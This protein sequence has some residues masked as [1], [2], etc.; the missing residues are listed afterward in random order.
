MALVYENFIIDDTNNFLT[1]GTAVF[2]VDPNKIAHITL[3]G[4]DGQKN[5][6]TVGTINNTVNDLTTAIIDEMINR[7]GINN[8]IL[9]SPQQFLSSQG[10]SN[11]TNDQDFL[12]NLCDSIENQNIDTHISI[13]CFAHTSLFWAFKRMNP[14][15]PDISFFESLT[16]LTNNAN[17]AFFKDPSNWTFDAPI[18]DPS[19]LTSG[20]HFKPSSTNNEVGQ[21][22]NTS[23]VLNTSN[24]PL[25]VSVEGV[26][27]FPQYKI[28]EA[29]HFLKRN[30]QTPINWS[31]THELNFE[32]YIGDL[33]IGDSVFAVS[34]T[35]F[36]T[37][38]ILKENEITL[39]PPLTTVCNNSGESFIGTA[40]FYSN[41]STNNTLWS[42]LKTLDLSA[43]NQINAQA[44]YT[45]ATDA[46]IAFE[47]LNTLDLSSVKSIDDK[48]FYNKGPKGSNAW[49]SVTELNLKDLEVMNE[50]TF[51]SSTSTG[52]NNSWQK[53]E[54]LNIPTLETVPQ[55][56]FESI[57][58]HINNSWSNLTSITLTS[59]ITI[60]E[61]AFSS[62]ST[63]DNNAFQKLA[64]L[65]VPNTD[66]I[67]TKAFSS[68]SSLAK[69]NA[70]RKITFLDLSSVST[71]DESAF[72]ALGETENNTFEA[73]VSLV[74]SIKVILSD[75]SFFTFSNTTN[76]SFKN[77][78]ALISTDNSTVNLTVATLNNAF[79]KQ[80]QSNTP[81]PKFKNNV[82]PWQVT[83]GLT[84]K[85][86][87][88]L[89][90]GANWSKVTTQRNL[91]IEFDP[92][93]VLT[94][95]T[96]QKITIKGESNLQSA[97][98]DFVLIDS[99][100]NT[101]GPFSVIASSSINTN[102][103]FS[104]TLNINET[105]QPGE[106]TLEDVTALNNVPS[107]SIT[108]TEAVTK[109]LLVRFFPFL[110]MFSHIIFIALLINIT[111][112]KAKATA[113]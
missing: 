88:L 53:V 94:I 61:E 54:T 39:L 15:S 9:I 6:I 106:Y 7:G 20:T 87:M 25:L 43:A 12:D 62:S 99:N 90:S 92:N 2:Y 71:I 89:S 69:N 68:Q 23:L 63:Q 34:N 5:N 45:E 85:D 26:M 67:K 47:N 55:K 59:A 109:P 80:D 102:N 8:M 32:N 4:T 11:L 16:N 30:A 86:E 83:P 77:L 18:L 14:V 60:D 24:Q 110:V 33:L 21:Y 22:I 37:V 112:R 107:L 104:F 56:S 82:I 81:N 105:L 100:Q 49:S 70:F 108:I 31:N 65:D 40:A 50:E 93:N 13:K 76:N 44:F 10:G 113:N 84:F 35:N 91:E 42:S 79:L 17:L 51:A 19:N 27:N 3:N 101:F 58:G 41:I 72:Y 38:E 46:N 96:K 28:T 75:F 98:G 95:P 36:N 57:S 48:A 29:I 64:L 111:T 78:T 66:A 52:T 103:L 97:R 73:L 1:Q 74:L